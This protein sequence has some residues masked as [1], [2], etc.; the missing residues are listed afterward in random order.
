M[1][2]TE[3]LLP[4]KGQSWIHRFIFWQAISHLIHFHFDQFLIFIKSYSRLFNYVFVFQL[5]IIGFWFSRHHLIKF[6][7]ILRQIFQFPRYCREPPLKKN[8]IFSHFYL[9]SRKFCRTTNASG[10]GV[11]AVVLNRTTSCECFPL[12]HRNMDKM[13]SVLG[14]IYIEI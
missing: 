2:Q 5:F 13:F 3:L 10:Q 12:I 7:T 6:F 8:E 1:Y 9:K 4:K 14:K 11:T